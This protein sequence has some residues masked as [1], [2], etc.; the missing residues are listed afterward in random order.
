MVFIY[1]YFTLTD[2]LIGSI[3]DFTTGLHGVHVLL[4]SFLVYIIIFYSMFS[5]IYPVYF[6]D[7]FF[8]LFLSSHH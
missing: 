6:M 4:G 5:L 3:H 1:S 7:F 8:S 2:C